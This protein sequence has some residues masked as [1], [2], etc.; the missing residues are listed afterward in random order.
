MNKVIV[1]ACYQ[2]RVLAALGDKPVGGS[3]DKAWPGMGLGS[4]TWVLGYFKVLVH[5]FLDRG[6]RVNCS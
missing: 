1:R 3:A 4:N 2:D 6:C 5:K